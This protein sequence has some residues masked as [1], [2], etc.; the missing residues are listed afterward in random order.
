[1]FGQS[2]LSFA[3]TGDSFESII[4]L[5]SR[6]PKGIGRNA[7]VNAYTDRSTP[8]ATGEARPRPP[9]AGQDGYDCFDGPFSIHPSRSYRER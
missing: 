8:A 4:L 2:V 3:W 6:K 9:G 7:C 1:M 5:G